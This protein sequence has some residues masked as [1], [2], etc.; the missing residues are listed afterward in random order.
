MK[1]AHFAQLSGVKAFAKIFGQP[2]SELL[3][4]CVAIRSPFLAALL[5][6]NAF[7][8]FPVCFDHRKVDRCICFVA[9]VAQN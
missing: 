9:S 3:E 1:L 8:D 2:R 5:L 6:Y 4:Q 7:A